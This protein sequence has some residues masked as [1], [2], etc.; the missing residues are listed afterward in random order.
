MPT[1]RME[2]V[3]NWFRMENSVFVISELSGLRLFIS[4]RLMDI[5]DEGKED[6]VQ[7]KVSDLRVMSLVSYFVTVIKAPG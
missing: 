2:A 3:W 7:W 1:L 4:S 6:R 5:S